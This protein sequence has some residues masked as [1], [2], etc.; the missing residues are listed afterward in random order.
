M[1]KA[2]AVLEGGHQ[3]AASSATIG[4]SLIRCSVT[5]VD[6]FACRRAVE[7]AVEAWLGAVADRAVDQVCAMMAEAARVQLIERLSARDV[8]DA[9]AR[10]ADALGPQ[11]RH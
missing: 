9:V 6:E 2:A 1:R 8:G 5:T 10:I 7:E 4:V 11:A 3:P